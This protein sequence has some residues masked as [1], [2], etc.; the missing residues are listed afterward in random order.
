MGYMV[1]WCKGIADKEE[2]KSALMSFR[3]NETILFWNEVIYVFA[4]VDGIAL[5]LSVTFL[6]LFPRRFPNSDTALVFVQI[7]LLYSSIVIYRNDVIREA[8]YPREDLGFAVIEPKANL[9]RGV[10]FAGIA[11][12]SVLLLLL[13]TLSS[14]SG[15]IE[16]VDGSVFGREKD[17]NEGNL[18][19]TTR[20]TAGKFFVCVVL[21][22]VLYF[23]HSSGVQNWVEVHYSDFD[24]VKSTKLTATGIC[25]KMA[26]PEVLAKL[27]IETAKFIE[28]SKNFNSNF[29]ESLQK[30][31]FTNFFDKFVFFVPILFAVF[32]LFFSTFVSV[33]E[34]DQIKILLFLIVLN[35]SNL[36]AFNSF[37]VIIENNVDAWP[38]GF[39]EI[40]IDDGFSDLNTAALMILFCLLF[41]LI[42]F[43]AP[44]QVPLM[45]QEE[46]ELLP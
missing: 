42:V 17:Q 34:A 2:I 30:A 25:A 44:V 32:Y 46:K 11:A 4:S 7:A 24:H 28:K 29:A 27:E 40:I 12:Q 35:I 23:M 8:V 38:G 33:K 45:N 20:F 19:E 36:I 37:V 13:A 3:A 21:F 1:S 43:F 16:P 10:T 9:L 15:N 22:A 6:I 18:P 14:V 39:Y 31:F 5:F 26:K 41:E